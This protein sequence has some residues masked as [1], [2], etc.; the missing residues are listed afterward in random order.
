M[1][2]HKVWSFPTFPISKQLFVASGQAFDGGMT[3]G[4]IHMLSP[5]PGGR[6]M[7]EIQPSLQ[8]SEWEFPLSSWLMSKINGDIFR[9][10]LA[11]TPQVASKRSGG[12]PWAEG[13]IYPESPWSNQQNWSGD[14]VALYKSVSLEGTNVAYVDMSA[15]GQILQ[16]GHVIG[17][18]DNCYKIDEVSY[19]AFNVATITVKP[20]FRKSIAVGDIALLRPFFLGS[21]VNGE[22]MRATYD[23]ENVGHIQIGRIRLNEVIL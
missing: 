6:S 17:H 12:A 5:E 11:P 23:A 2:N 15:L 4:G 21:I 13:G 16:C 18:G 22:E 1:I 19:D 8:V 7:L 10:R 14:D 9:V 3:V 20:P